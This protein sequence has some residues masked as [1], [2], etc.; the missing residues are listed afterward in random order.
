V[1]V[2]AATIAAPLSD[3]VVRGTH[4]GLAGLSADELDYK[5]KHS[6]E[7]LETLQGE[8]GVFGYPG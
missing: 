5:L 6:R 4:R 8:V 7:V 3:W 2:A 1:L